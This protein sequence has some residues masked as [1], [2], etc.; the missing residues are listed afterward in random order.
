[1]EWTVFGETMTKYRSFWLIIALQLY[2]RLQYIFIIINENI[3]FFSIS[4]IIKLQISRPLR[5]VWLV[6]T[7][8][9][10]RYGSFGL[11]SNSLR[12]VW[13]W[14]KG[15]SQWYGLFPSKNT[16]KRVFFPLRGHIYK[17][18]HYGS[19]GDNP[20]ATTDRVTWGF[21][22]NIV[23][24]LEPFAIYYINTLHFGHNHHFYWF[25]D[26][27]KLERPIH[28]YLQLVVTDNPYVYRKQALQKTC[29]N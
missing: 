26:G 29:S 17:Y 27:E 6:Y 12:I 11:I 19:C 13:V 20:Q 16:K 28:R 14:Q 21:L 2:I 22:F 3:D 4:A 1:M 25:Q 5:I 24:S 10:G 7:T 9:S 18:P 15:L 8:A 23:L